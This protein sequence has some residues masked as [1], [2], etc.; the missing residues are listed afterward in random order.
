MVS[1]QF[2]LRTIGLDHRSLSVNTR[3]I[4]KMNFL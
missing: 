3:A 1:E 4:G 2:A